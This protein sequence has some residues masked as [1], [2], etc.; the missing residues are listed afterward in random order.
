MKANSGWIM[1]GVGGAA[2]VLA[3]SWLAF[4]GGQPP[5]GGQRPPFSLPVTLAEVTAREVRPA[6][7]LTGSLR[8]P[9]RARVAFE[10][11][12]VISTLHVEEADPIR[13][14][15]PLA[16]LNGADQALA[17][18]SRQAELTVAERELA[19]L[20][21]GAREQEKRR[22]QA[23]VEIARA[24]LALA[25]LEVERG[26]ALLG[27]DVISKADLDRLASA[28]DAARARLAAA[29]ERLAEA[30]AGT[31]EEVLAIA[32][33]RVEQARSALRIAQREQEKT[34]LRAPWDGAVV[35]RRVAVGDFVAAGAPALELVDPDRLEVD[36][37]IPARYAARLGPRPQ[38]V[39]T[40]DE[41]PWFRLE[42]TLDAQV[43]VADELSRNFAGIV[44]LDR[45]QLG[46]AAAAEVLRP[47]MFVRL[48]LQLAPLAGQRVVPADA[49]RITSN[50]PVVVR[51]AAAEAPAS[52]SPIT[53]ASAKPP[54]LTAEWVPVRVLGADA[55][56][57]AVEPLSGAL[58]VGDRVV[59]TGVDL[60]F[61]GAPLDPRPEPPEGEPAD[62]VREQQTP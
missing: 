14:G 7:Q 2:V 53:E 47:G 30:E 34:V 9:R 48:E 43:P 49:V 28:E 33:A 4:G 54:G 23:E 57:R 45:R 52:A 35:A 21:A 1:L 42:A 61:P 22:L 58:A 46:D 12:G 24:E 8:A 38:V 26:R 50:G 5:A 55:R 37:A 10:V 3:A 27:R 44:R 25:G 36:V 11:A 15:Q 29:A 31:R 51:A 32:E 39:L 60:A 62:R 20:R 41:L 40:L 56:G 59:V 13:Q 6:V 18:A 17:A 19:N 16:R